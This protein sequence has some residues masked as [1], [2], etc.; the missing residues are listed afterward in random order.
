M[1]GQNIE[2]I[3]KAGLF[4]LQSGELVERRLYIL[5]ERKSFV[6]Y[7]EISKVTNDKPLYE[8]LDFK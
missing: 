1:E 8:T 6:K 3:V 4:V 2:R 5:N 7:F